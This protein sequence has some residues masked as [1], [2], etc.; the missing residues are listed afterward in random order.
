MKKI[1]K[2]DEELIALYIDGNVD[3][4]EMLINRHKDK[5]YTSILL[6][7]HERYVADDIFQ[8]TFVKIIKLFQKGKYVES[9]RFIGLAMRIARN[10]TLDYFRTRKFKPQIY[11]SNSKD[12]FDNM[13]FAEVNQLDLIINEQNK[14]DL[15]SLIKQLPEEQREVLMLRHY[16]DLSF[17]EIAD[18][19]NCSVNTAL[20]RMR[21]AILALRKMIVSQSISF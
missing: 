5:I 16:A 20:G 17:K 21:Y 11:D 4:M 18:I 15:R 9:G 10:L 2:S 19:C 8:E 14:C 13:K 7:V 3:C 6:L 12:I 1:Q